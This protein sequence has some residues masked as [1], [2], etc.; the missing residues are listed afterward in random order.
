VKYDATIRGSDRHGGNRTPLFSN[1][2]REGEKAGDHA[3]KETRRYFTPPS[4]PCRRAHFDARGK[5]A[6]DGPA[7]YFSPDGEGRRLRG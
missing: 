5:L 6:M 3:S 7:R 4:P 1:M 2:S